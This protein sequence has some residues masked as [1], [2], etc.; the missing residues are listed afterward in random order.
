MESDDVVVEAFLLRKGQNGVPEGPKK[1][2]IVGGFVFSGETWRRKVQKHF[3]SG[4]VVAEEQQVCF[5]GEFP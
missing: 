5:S 2:M 4:R 1:S 3:G